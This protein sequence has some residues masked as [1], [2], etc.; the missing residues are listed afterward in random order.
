MRTMRTIPRR[1]VVTSIFWQQLLAYARSLVNKN[2]GHFVSHKLVM[3]IICGGGVLV[4]TFLGEM[5]IH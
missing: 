4:A 5:L 3:M 2:N 1:N